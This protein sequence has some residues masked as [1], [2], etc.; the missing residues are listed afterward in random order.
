[1]K[2]ELI[3]Y[4]ALI[5]NTLNKAKSSKLVSDAVDLVLT[6]DKKVDFNDSFDIFTNFEKELYNLV[7]EK[8]V[9]FSDLDSLDHLN[10][11]YDNTEKL[12]FSFEMLK[13]GHLIGTFS[14]AEQDYEKMREIKKKYDEE[15]CKEIESA[16]AYLEKI[17]SKGR[18]QLVKEIRYFFEHM[19]PVTVFI[20]QTIFS[21][22]YNFNN[23]HPKKEKRTGD[24]LFERLNTYDYLQWEQEEKLFIYCMKALIISGIQTRLEEV[25]RQQISIQSINDFFNKK[26]LYYQNFVTKSSIEWETL[27]LFEKASFLNVIFSDIKENYLIYREINGLSLQ[28]KEIILKDSKVTEESNRIKISFDEMINR[29]VQNPSNSEDNLRYLLRQDVMNNECSKYQKIVDYIL[30]SV[31]KDT[32]TDVSFCR[33]YTNIGDL[34]DLVKNEKYLSIVDKNSQ[35]YSCYIYPN[36]KLRKM[37]PRKMLANMA[38][39]ISSRMIY[40]SWHYIPGNFVN[41]NIDLSKREYYFP[42]IIP[43]ITIHDKYHHIGHVKLSV[44]NCIRSPAHLYIHGKRMNALMDI[45]LLRMGDKIYSTKDLELAT[46]YTKLLA[47]VM[48]I[49]IDIVHEQE[50]D[51]SITKY[52]K[53]WYEQNL[54]NRSNNIEEKNF[55]H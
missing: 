13:D 15:F 11:F 51:F 23:L 28:K 43:D 27:G 52:T 25:N 18:L 14:L 7:K 47:N 22:F 20:K 2:D 36:K 32:D 42:P 12:T 54:N 39:A 45:R 30:E 3:N 24:F 37:M 19:A 40:N 48:Q 49:L 17:G 41:E 34:I 35:E 33:F 10:L 50:K 26:F 53:Q 8:R 4:E 9:E 55:I 5:E 46:V 38:S 1:M 21:N 6:L 31:A 44:N 16:N 29:M